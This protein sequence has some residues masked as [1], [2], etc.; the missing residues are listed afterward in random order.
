MCPVFQVE[1]AVDKAYLKW[2]PL[3]ASHVKMLGHQRTEEGKEYDRVYCI[4]EE[5]LTYNLPVHIN[6]YRRL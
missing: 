6:G 3:N 2:P 4:E 1:K 5:Y